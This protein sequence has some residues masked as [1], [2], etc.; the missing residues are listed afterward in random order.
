[1]R[2]IEDILCPPPRRASYLDRDNRH[3]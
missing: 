1:V 3:L 2:A